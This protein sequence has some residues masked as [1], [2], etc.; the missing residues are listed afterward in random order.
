MERANASMLRDFKKMRGVGRIPSTYNKNEVQFK[1]I[2]IFYEFVDS[3]LSLLGSITD[4]IKFPVMILDINWSE[5]LNHSLLHQLT[6]GPCLLLVH[7]GLIGQ[8]NL[9]QHGIRIKVLG[10]GILKMIQKCLFISTVHNVINHHFSLLHIL[11][12][13]VI[14][15]E[16][17]CGD[18]L[19]MGILSMNDRSQSLFLMSV[20]SVPNLAHP[21][22]G[23]VNDIDILVVHQFHFLERRSKCRKD[24]NISIAD[25]GK[26]FLSLSQLFNELHIHIVQF[27]INLGV[28]NKFISDVNRLS[29]EMLN[30]LIGEGNTA[31]N[32]PA[33]PKVFGKVHF[34]T[35]SLEHEIIGFELIDQL[36]FELFFH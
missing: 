1:V 10:Y 20:D 15:A 27:V 29:R 4:S 24:Y 7:S 25:I 36:R 30:G 34:H 19:F 6:D 14:L 28:V 33:E 2:C 11:H 13:N 23:G 18:S 31:L 8:S 32:T 9:V 3:I 16:G 17:N 22:A 21:W 35:I 12:T 26:I 5:L